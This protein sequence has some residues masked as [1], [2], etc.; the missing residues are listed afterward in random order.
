MN[1][2]LHNA[3]IQTFVY[4]FTC[5]MLYPVKAAKLP[6]YHTYFHKQAGTNYHQN[7]SLI[8]FGQKLRYAARMVYYRTKYRKNDFNQA[9]LHIEAELKKFESM[10]LELE[11]EALHAIRQKYAINDETWYKYTQDVVKIKNSS[12]IGMTK[13]HKEVTHDP[14]I[15][16]D[17]KDMLI[18]FLKENNMNP[19]S[20]NIV[21]ANEQTVEEETPNTLAYTIQ[22]IST[23]STDKNLIILEKYTPATIVIFPSLVQATEET[24]LSTCAHEIQHL[25][26]HHSPLLSLLNEYLA[27]YCSVAKADFEQTSEYRRLTQIYEAQAEILTA[28]SN[29]YTARSI[30]ATRQKYYY[31][32]HLYEEHFYHIS[33]INMLW[34]LHDKLEGLYFK[35]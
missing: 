32:N 2:R 21:M 16:E 6:W 29:P 13:P 22:Y 12:K 19:E 35:A 15:P 26:C 27:Y 25:A 34:K 4:L 7:C 28:I 33:T 30:N 23:E 17:I 10:L 18:M 5:C 3:R 14:A 31:P 20:I 9:L 24:K 8:A 1:F 11:Q